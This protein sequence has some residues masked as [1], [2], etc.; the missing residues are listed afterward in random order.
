MEGVNPSTTDL[1]DLLES[2]VDTTPTANNT[3]YLENNN[4]NSDNKDIN[5]NPSV[6]DL[7]DLLGST[8]LSA[9]DDPAQS[10]ITSNNDMDI[11]NNN[12]VSQ[13][14]TQLNKELNNNKSNATLQ[15]I[16]V[17]TDPDY[18]SIMNSLTNNNNNYNNTAN[19]QYF[20]RGLRSPTRTPPN[21]H[22]QSPSPFVEHPAL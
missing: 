16:S 7:K 13:L 22:M 5:A 14:N 20:G 18:G 10:V 15:E 6:T 19:E 12:A 8:F 1:K 4:I 9:N 21:N 3:F 17:V 2:S 11:D